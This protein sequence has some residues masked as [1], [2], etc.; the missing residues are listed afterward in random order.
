MRPAMMETVLETV[1]F[2]LNRKNRNLRLF[3]FGKTYQTKEVGSYQEEKW[4]V[5]AVTGAAAEAGWRIKEKSADLFYLK[6]IVANLLAVAHAEKARPS[7]YQ[8]DYLN[9]FSLGI[10]QK[11][12]ATIGEVSRKR[13]QTFDIKQPVWY[14]AIQ[15][16]NLLETAT[17]GKVQ[18]SE[19]PRY[20][21]VDRDLALLVNTGTTWQQM[22]DVTT[23]ARVPQLQKVQLFDVFESEKLGPGKQSMALSLRFQDNEKT[24]T[25]TEIDAAMQKIAGLLEQELN[26]EVRK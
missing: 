7:V 22:A 8:S 6:G 26:A 12:I 17:K 2:N 16:D 9:G 10:G 19:I 14:A 18:Y 24:M 13:L 23:K 25:D 4:L 21:S 5:L 3:E 15:W 11:T 1:A 20:P